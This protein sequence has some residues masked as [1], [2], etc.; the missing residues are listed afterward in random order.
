[1]AVNETAKLLTL[2]LESG[3]EPPDDEVSERILDAALGLVA[4]SGVRHLTMDDVA[5]RAGVGRMTVYRRFGNRT[6]LVE[7]LGVREC[8]G[9]LARIAAALDP[10]APVDVRLARLFVAVIRE[11]HTHPMLARL[12]RVEPETF[13]AEMTTPDGAVVALARGFTVNMLREC[14]AKG[15]LIAIDPVVLAEIWL[16]LGISFVLMPDS[17][18]AVEDETR[19][20]ETV[21][22]VLAPYLVTK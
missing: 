9:V 5:L 19:S 15:E 22:Q 3:V 21:R 13:L 7:A 10:D 17:V 18:I 12:A 1:M 16:R 20:L 11:V 4:A 2:A 6:E 14:Q 8:R